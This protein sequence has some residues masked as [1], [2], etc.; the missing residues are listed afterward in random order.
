MNSNS[1]RRLASVC[2]FCKSHA[3]RQTGGG[4]AVVVNYH[5]VYSRPTIITSQELQ[6]RLRL[7]SGIPL[8]GP[9]VEFGVR[10]INARATESC[11]GS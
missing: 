10:L 4:G 7:E 6:Q 2:L 1:V 8:K 9:H 5:L 3:C 11:T